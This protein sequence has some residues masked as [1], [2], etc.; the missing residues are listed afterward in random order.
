MIFKGHRSKAAY[1]VFVSLTND[2]YL[3]EACMEEIVKAKGN[4]R[5]AADQM[6]RWL[7]KKTPVGTPFTKTSVA[8]ALIEIKELQ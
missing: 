1:D 4:C 6:M 3:V 8:E 5:L 7:P 2:Q